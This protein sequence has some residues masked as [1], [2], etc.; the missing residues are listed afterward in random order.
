MRSAG[1]PPMQPQLAAVAEQIEQD[2]V[3]EAF[4]AGIQFAVRCMEDLS[5]EF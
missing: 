4:T 1:R 5:F 2:G 3:P